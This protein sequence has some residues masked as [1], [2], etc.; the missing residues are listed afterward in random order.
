MNRKK[1]A[2]QKGFRSRKCRVGSAVSLLVV[3]ALV[4]TLVPV[5][6]FA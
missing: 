4:F 2:M 1:Y 3:L 6:A 5:A